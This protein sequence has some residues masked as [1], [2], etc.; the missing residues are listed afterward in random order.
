M[1]RN[2]EQLSVTSI[3]SF[4]F[5]STSEVVCF[6][7]YSHMHSAVAS[8]LNHHSQDMCRFHASNHRL[9]NKLQ[10]CPTGLFAFDWSYPLIQQPYQEYFYTQ[11]ESGFNEESRWA[12]DEVS[13]LPA[14][15]V[16]NDE[17]HP[18]GYPK[19]CRSLGLA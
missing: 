17:R 2:Y 10:P 1:S 7:P 6:G 16:S 5:P 12:H 4:A 11:G 14:F 3:F 8:I 15:V 13:I 19:C 18:C 9:E